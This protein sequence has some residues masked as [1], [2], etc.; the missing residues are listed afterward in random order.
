MTIHTA[1]TT[2]TATTTTPTT[3]TATASFPRNCTPAARVTKSLLGYGVIAGPFYVVTSL[4]QALTRDG[5]DPTKHAWN[6]LSN[7]ALGWIQITNFLLTGLMTIAAAVGLRR[8]LGGARVTSGHL[9][10]SVRTAPALSRW[11][12]SAQ[13]LRKASQSA[14]PIRQR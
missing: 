4:A 9:G 6:L 8:A 3:T 1:P 5:F 13:T 7:G 2:T 11:G 10:C 14:R 12:S